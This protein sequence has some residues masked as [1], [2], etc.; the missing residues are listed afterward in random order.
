MDSTANCVKRDDE[1]ESWFGLFTSLSCF[2]EASLET[3]KIVAGVSYF[4]VEFVL[5]LSLLCVHL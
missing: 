2:K 4:V 5:G 3:I 1:G